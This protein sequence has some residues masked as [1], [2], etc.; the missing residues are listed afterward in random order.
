MMKILEAEGRRKDTN[1]YGVALLQWRQEEDKIGD[2]TTGT[3]H[4]EARKAEGGRARWSQEE[5]GMPTAR[6]IVPFLK[7]GPPLAPLKRHE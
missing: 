4:L 7:A 2:T 3:P 5:R 6:G 1:P